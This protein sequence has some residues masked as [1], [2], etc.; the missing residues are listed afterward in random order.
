MSRNSFKPLIIVM[1]VLTSVF[2]LVLSMGCGAERT[3]VVYTIDDV[4]SPDLDSSQSSTLRAIEGAK[5]TYYAMYDEYPSDIDDLI[6]AEVL[7]MPSDTGEDTYFLQIV[8]G[9]PVAAIK[10]YK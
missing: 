6:E 10:F 3:L 9:E 1:V 7:K 5:A 8:D 2:L 4:T